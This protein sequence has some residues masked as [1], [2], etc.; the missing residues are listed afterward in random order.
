M[1]GVHDLGGMHGFGP[2]QVEPDEP[3]FHAEWERRALAVTL[4]TGALGRWTIDRS[5]HVRES[6][7]PAT[8]LSSSYYEIW[9]RGLQRLLAESGLLEQSALGEESRLMAESGLVEDSQEAEAPGQAGASGHAATSGLHNAPGQP[10]E[11]ADGSP[12]LAKDWPTIRASL[13]RGTPYERA[14]DALARFAVGDRVRT[15]GRHP[16]G[17]TRL[18][19][20]ARGKLGEVVAVRGAHVYPDENADPPGTASPPGSAVEWLYTVVFDGAELFGEDA[21]PTVTVTIDAF[22][23]YLRPADARPEPS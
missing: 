14:I 20:Y 1:D 16:A 21:D 6:L 5:R 3:V 2:V 11:T 12:S 18:P 22:E 13:D 19:R 17:H 9:I 8:Y 7:P 4:A 10:R 23:P 15:I